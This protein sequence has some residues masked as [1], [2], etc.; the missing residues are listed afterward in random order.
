MLPLV[1]S[2]KISLRSYTETITEGKHF[3]RKLPLI[4]PGKMVSGTEI[5]YNM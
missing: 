2:R 1:L 3:L 5:E 4:E